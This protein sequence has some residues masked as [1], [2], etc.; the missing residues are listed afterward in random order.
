MSRKRRMSKKE[1]FERKSEIH[2]MN[3]LDENTPIRMRGVFAALDEDAKK[4]IKDAKP[5]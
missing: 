4:R 2:R 1:D 5:A 3:C